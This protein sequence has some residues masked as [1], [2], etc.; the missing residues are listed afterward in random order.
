MEEAGPLACLSPLP[1][2][3]G[4]CVPDALCAFLLQ[5]REP[6]SRLRSCSVTD[7][8]AEQAH[9]PPVTHTRFQPPVGSLGFYLIFASS[10]FSKT[11]LNTWKFTVHI[12]LK[13]VSF[14]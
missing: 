9:L 11:S 12:L 3:E 2:V 8:V 13:L 6:S 5:Q 7:A 10:A 14:V 4:V 1:V